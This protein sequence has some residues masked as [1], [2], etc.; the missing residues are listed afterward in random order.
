MHFRPM[1]FPGKNISTFLIMNKFPY[2]YEAE[3]FFIQGC[4][5]NSGIS[6]NLHL[7]NPH[8]LYWTQ[9]QS[10][11]MWLFLC[12]NMQRWPHLFRHF[13][14]VILMT[15][16]ESH[17]RTTVVWDSFIDILIGRR[18]TQT[19]NNLMPNYF[20]LNQTMQKHTWL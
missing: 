18:N 8:K 2:T 13:C 5:G 10:Y 4:N 6:G 19:A 14:Y 12:M 3:Q 9:T 15:I 16:L 20:I 11:S 1:S 17:L 7:C